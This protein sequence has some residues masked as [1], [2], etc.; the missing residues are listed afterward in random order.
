MPLFRRKQLSQLVLQPHERV[1]DV[2][3]EVRSVEVKA[4]RMLTDVLSGGYRSTFRGMGVEFSDVR[5][6]VEGDDQRSVDWNVTARI[7]RPFVKRFVEERERTLVFVLDLAPSMAL[8]LGAWS[9]RQAAA[10][11]CAMLGLVAADNHDRVGLVTRSAVGPRYVVPQSGGGHV[12]RVVRDC[13]E[14]PCG[15]GASLGDLIST[16]NARVRRRAVVFVLSDFLAPGYEHALR[17]SGRHHDVVAVRFLSQELTDPPRRLLRAMQP[18]SVADQQAAQLCDFTSDAYR[19]AWSTRVAHWRE[20]H[21]DLLGRARIDGIDVEIP[22]EA[23]IKIL[24]QPLLR[25][26]RSRQQREVG[27]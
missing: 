4:T 20:Q 10:R 2:L 3:A 19:S 26:F 6:Y 7:G 18:G 8:G 27:R 5:E 24:A 11:Y 15:D 23:D 17:L 12:F 9:L 21:D 1:G 25:F 13:V 22:K 14:L 16:V